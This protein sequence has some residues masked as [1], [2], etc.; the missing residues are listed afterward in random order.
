[1][2]T[3]VTYRL[4]KFPSFKLEYGNLKDKVNELG[5]ATLHNVRRAVCEIRDA[6]LPNPDKIGSAGSFF[7]NPVVV[8]DVAEKLKKEYPTMPQYALSCGNVKLSAGWLI[9]QCGW[10]NKPHE[11]VGV[12]EFQ[13]L[14][15]INRGGATG[16]DVIEFAQAVVDSVKDKF[17]VELRMEVNTI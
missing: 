4:K 11:H 5:G 10:K 12:Y 14:V 1:M 16:K 9:E 7:M 2:I 15:V 17:G 6:K 8:A 3:F 13:A